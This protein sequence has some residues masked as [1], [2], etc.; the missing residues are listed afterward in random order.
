MAKEKCC[1]GGSIE[2]ACG[3]RTGSDI[4][5]AMLVAPE[6]VGVDMSSR[7]TEGVSIGKTALHRSLGEVVGSSHT[8]AL[9]RALGRAL[10][11]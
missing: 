7:A 3:A 2:V 6:Q 1:V 8:D 10:E 4:V 11:R 9:R 5:G